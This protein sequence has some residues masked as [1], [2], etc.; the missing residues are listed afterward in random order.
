[1]DSAEGNDSTD[2][3]AVTGS[4]HRA[5]SGDLASVS[6]YVCSNCVLAPAEV[7]Q[8]CPDQRP[9]H[10]EYVPDSL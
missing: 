3:E 7:G 8:F 2:P 9:T 10:S 5:F 6:C 1:M 4:T